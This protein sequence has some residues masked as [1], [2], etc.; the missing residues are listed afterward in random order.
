MRYTHKSSKAE[1]RSFCCETWQC[2]KKRHF[3][4]YTRSK[5][6]TKPTPYIFPLLRYSSNY[7]TL[8]NATQFL[9]IIV[10][11]QKDEA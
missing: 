5:Q 6:G 3:S 11:Y 9:K 2:Q 8:K 7:F 1:A 4:V 10:Y